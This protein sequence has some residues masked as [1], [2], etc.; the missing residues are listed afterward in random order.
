MAPAFSS[1]RQ[2]AG[3]LLLLAALLLLPLIA[4]KTG[5]LSRANAYATMPEST[6]PFSFQHQQIFKET[7][8]VDIA[9]IGASVV[10]FQIDTPHVQRALSEHLNREARVIALASLW[11]AEDR[12]YFVL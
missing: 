3:F 9:F 5:L 2:A 4:G 10:L 6:G 8:D 12:N 1:T 11:G 7:S